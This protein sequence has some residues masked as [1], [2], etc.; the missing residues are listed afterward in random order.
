MV[1]KFEGSGLGQ[2]DHSS[3]LQRLQTETKVGRAKHVATMRIETRDD[4]QA[5][6][7]QTRQFQRLVRICPDEQ[8][9]VDFIMEDRKSGHLF[10]VRPKVA[11]VGDLIT[12]DSSMEVSPYDPIQRMEH[13]IDAAGKRLEFPLTDILRSHLR[14]I[15]T[16]RPGTTR[17]VWL[18]RPPESSADTVHAV[19][20]NCSFVP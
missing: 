10:E 3:L 14:S 11:L 9:E 19:F 4:V 8:G 7:D 20:L 17:L 16:F 1:R 2:S 18:Y 5:T 12:L 13:V 15:V 6:V